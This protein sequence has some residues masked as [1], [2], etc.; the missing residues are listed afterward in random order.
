[1]SVFTS[2]DQKRYKFD[3]ITGKLEVFGEKPDFNSISV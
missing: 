3:E 2:M 1:M